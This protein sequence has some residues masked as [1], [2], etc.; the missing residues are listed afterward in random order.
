MLLSPEILLFISE[1]V[2]LHVNSHLIMLIIKSVNLFDNLHFLL[3]LNR[4]KVVKIGD[5]KLRSEEKEKAKC[6]P[7]DILLKMSIIKI[8]GVIR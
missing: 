2:I 1:V 7:V 3:L 4:E 5:L 8:Q 6:R